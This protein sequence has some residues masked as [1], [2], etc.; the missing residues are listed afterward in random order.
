MKKLWYEIEVIGC[1]DS[2]VFEMELSQKEFE[3]VNRVAEK[4]NENSTYD[5]MPRMEIKQI[6][7]GKER[8]VQ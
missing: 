5:C 6:E 4:C 1:D 2:T 7:R 3:I 8:I